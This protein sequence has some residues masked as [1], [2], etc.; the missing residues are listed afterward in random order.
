MLAHTRTE[1]KAIA[2]KP[3]ILSRSK[4][5]NKSCF[6]PNSSCLASEVFV[7]SASSYP[8]VWIVTDEEINCAWLMMAATPSCPHCGSTLV[9]THSERIEVIL[10]LM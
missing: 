9:A 4:A 7:R 2:E 3:F 1:S 10:P 5:A 8:H 6:C